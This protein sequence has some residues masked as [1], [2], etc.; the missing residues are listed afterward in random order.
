M[1]PLDRGTVGLAFKACKEPKMRA[2]TVELL[3]RA[4]QE[5]I[6]AIGATQ[7]DVAAHHQACSVRLSAKALLQLAE[8]DRDREATFA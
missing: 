8:E 1:R 5:A 3:K 2:E 7:P 4:S 6:R